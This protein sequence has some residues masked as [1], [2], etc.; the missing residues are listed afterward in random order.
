MDRDQNKRTME[1]PVIV[2]KED[3]FIWNQSQLLLNDER[4]ILVLFMKN[5]CI[6]SEDALS[7]LMLLGQR[8]DVPFRIAVCDV[9]GIQDKLS[10]S[11]IQLNRVPFFAIFSK[12]KILYKDRLPPIWDNGSIRRPASKE[13]P[14]YCTLDAA[15]GASNK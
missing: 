11:S 5:D 8:K 13:E 2:V 4:D 14:P 15:Y 12:R 1:T 3:D 9:A 6:H 10:N 7:E